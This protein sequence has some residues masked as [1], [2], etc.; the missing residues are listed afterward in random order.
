MRRA[1]QVSGALLLAF[2]LAFAAGAR[3]YPYTTPNGPG[4]GFLPLWLGAVMAVLG[5]MLF[6]RASRAREAGPAWLP[7]GRA[8]AR[9]VV[10]IAATAVFIWVLPVLGMTVTTAIFLV[11]LLRFLEGHT[12]VTTL[13]V[14]VATAAANWLVFIRWLNVPFPP[15]VLGF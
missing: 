8:L 12:W 13:G 14:A 3:Q 2:A 9:L 11:G 10:V 15:G 5:G 4:S 7:G 6:V 1:D